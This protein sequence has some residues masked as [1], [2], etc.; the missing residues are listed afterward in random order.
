[1]DKAKIIKILLWIP[2]LLVLGV[3]AYYRLYNIREYQMFL[4]DQGR[5]VLVVKRMLVDHK[6]TLLGP[7]ASVGGFFLGPI[8]YYMMLIPLA[9][10]NLDPVGPAI[11]VALFSIATTYLCFW[12]G[13][14]FSNYTTG[15]VAASVYAVS[16]LV[17]DYARSSWNPNVLPFFSL[18]LVAAFAILI[19]GS[20][21]R[22]WFWLLII[23]ACLGIVVQLH[24]PA[25]ALFF[26]AV[27]LF[28][29]LSARHAYVTKHTWFKQSLQ[30]AGIILIGLFVLLSPFIIFELRHGHQNFNNIMQFVFADREQG[31]SGG[32][33][34]E[35]LVRDTAYRLFLR[36]VAGGN[37]FA[38][39]S[40][41][42][43]TVL[44]LSIALYKLVA[45]FSVAVK[46]RPQTTGF[47]SDARWYFARILN[48]KKAVGWLVLLF[49]FVIGVGFWG[50]YKKSIYD[51]YYSYMYPLPILMF[52]F[53]VGL[54]MS[55]RLRHTVLKVAALAVFI[56]AMAN[57]IKSVS[58]VFPSQQ[59]MRAEMVA[60]AVIEHKTDGPYNFALITSG[61][62]DHAYRYFLEIY[63]QR[64]LTLEEQVTPQLMVF[65]ETLECEPLGN[66][67]WEVAGFGPST[68]VGQWQA[69]GWP[70]YRL[71][72]LPETK[73][74][75]GKPAPKGA[76]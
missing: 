20:T 17:I 49:W 16:R 14:K 3:A 1:M 36:L 50:F 37:D 40:I 5:D 11:M 57:N 64:P 72:H 48:N 7:T 51:Y 62:S 31:F 24:Y 75:E 34:Y 46:Q 26:L 2:V 22:R 25:I 13:K 43:I 39:Y 65:C 41:M 15:L 27:P 53:S 29:L 28:M 76:L 19:T 44:G 35:F 18:L 45:N 71:E 61:N 69:I 59:V 32:Y 42:F 67:L 6:L 70:M 63:G 23:G 33:S 9:L 52:A 30:D 21:V 60:K 66:S 8:Y 12:F 55:L 74:L 58:T 47:P 4:G 56:L 68:I 73:Y 54:I 10:S 38:V